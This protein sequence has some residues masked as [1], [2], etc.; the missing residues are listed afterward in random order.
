MAAWY[1]ETMEPSATNHQAS[2]SNN[3]SYTAHLTFGTVQVTKG[4]Q[5]ASG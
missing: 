2:A 5:A 4:P 3:A 1:H